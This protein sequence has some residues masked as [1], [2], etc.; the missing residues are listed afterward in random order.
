MH[1]WLGNVP[2]YAVEFAQSTIFLSLTYAMFEPIRTSVLATNRI[3]KFLIIPESFYLLVLPI[4]YLVCKMTNDPILLIVTIV[5][6]DVLACVYRIYF[7]VKVSPLKT[8][9]LLKNIIFPSSTVAI[10]DCVICYGL[11]KIF[12]INFCGFM[13]LLSLNSVALSLIILYLGLNRS[14]RNLCFKMV[15]N[16]KEKIYKR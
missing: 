13:L 6:M 1:L 5:A 16:M 10:F 15:K 12:E 14:E 8:R 3:T 11:A 9:E 7:A 2:P 4:S